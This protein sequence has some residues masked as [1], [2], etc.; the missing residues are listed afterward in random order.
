MGIMQKL[1]TSMK[2]LLNETFFCNFLIYFIL[3]QLM[4]ETTLMSNL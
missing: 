2:K 4:Y 3:L 1:S